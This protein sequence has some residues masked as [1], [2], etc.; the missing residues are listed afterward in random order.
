[1]DA[2][3]NVLYLYLRPMKEA[4]RSLMRAA[5]DTWLPF[6]PFVSYRVDSS[7]LPMIPCTWTVLGKK[8]NECSHV[9]LC[10]PNLNIPPPRPTAPNGSHSD[11]VLSSSR[12][13]TFLTAYRMMGVIGTNL[14]PMICSSS[15]AP[16][17]SHCYWLIRIISSSESAYMH[18]LASSFKMSGSFT[19]VPLLFACR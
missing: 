13:S 19:T 9:V 2:W 15:S 6:C 4:V 3:M 5:V 1:M 12:Y 8:E 16:R 10:S 18:F 17:I 7:H 11:T 14:G